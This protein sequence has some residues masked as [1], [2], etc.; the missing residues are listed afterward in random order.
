MTSVWINLGISFLVVLVASLLAAQLLIWL[1]VRIAR[2]T[3]SE[4]DE[5]FLRA[6]RPQIYLLAVTLSLNFATA[7]WPDLPVLTR[8]TLDKLYFTIFVLLAAI[9]L[10]K[11]LDY[12]VLWYKDLAEKSGQTFTDK[13]AA[14]RLS[15]R[16]GKILVIFIGII[17]VLDN[18]GVNVSALVATLGIGGLAITL[19]AQD[20]FSNMISGIM[21]LVDEPFRIGDHIEIKGLDIWGE[22]V[23]VGLRS[24]RLRTTDNRMV[25]VPNVNIT[26]NQVINN[27]HPDPRF[28]MQVDVV[29]DNG[30]NRDFVR[31]VISRAVL[32]VEG[33][34]ADKPVDILLLEFN[35]LVTTMR[36]RWW[37]E[38][39]PDA[40][41]IF[42]KVNEAIFLALKD[43][44][45]EKSSTKYSTEIKT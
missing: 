14:L 41:G 27:T 38:C 36:V 20:T 17:L 37:A 21:I 9:I 33:V 30:E 6:I 8:Q 45:I 24:T 39:Y 32:S 7:R 3:A 42:N 35:D 28:R 2:R 18:Y 23:D 31:E 26:K 19:A 5:L 16:A 25:I 22:V 1:S 15:Q 10:W 43:A 40:R 12:L 29:V 11:L 4:Y 44:G 13:E 34:L